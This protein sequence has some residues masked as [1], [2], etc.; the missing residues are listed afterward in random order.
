[1]SGDKTFKIALL[2]SFIIHGAILLK[3][4][5]FLHFSKNKPL[6][7]TEVSYIKETERAKTSPAINPVEKKPILKLPA[8][9]TG[10]RKMPLPSFNKQDFLKENKVSLARKTDFI[11]PHP[12]K[13]EIMV[14]KKKIVLS[15]ANNAEKANSVAYISH[16][17]LIREKFKRA[18]HENY[19]GTETGQ[20]SISFIISNDGKLQEARI[21][22]EKSS[23]SPYLR[24]VALRSVKEASPFPVF[25]K[26][27]DYPQ[28]SFNVEISFEIE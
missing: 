7:E 26:E 25:P 10:K 5:E 16:A 19:T 18:L 1:M 20:V 6:P 17:Q 4:P 23:A 3:N 15:S 9:I 12:E 8:Q 28:L 24:E 11:K 21:L 2:I 14:V 22:E 13:P 27:L